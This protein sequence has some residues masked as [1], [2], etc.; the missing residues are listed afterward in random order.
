MTLFRRPVKCD[1][2]LD[3]LENLGQALAVML[4]H[5]QSARQDFLSNSNPDLLHRFDQAVTQVRVRSEQLERQLNALE[6]LV[7]KSR[8]L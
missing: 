5:A 2:F 8:L 6:Y 1:D 7:A 3:G 4:E